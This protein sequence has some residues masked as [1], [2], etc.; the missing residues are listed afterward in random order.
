MILYIRT[1][2]NS[3]EMTDL[4][5]LNKL[6]EFLRSESLS[7]IIIP[8]NDPHFGEY[9]QDYYKVIGWLSGFTGEA[10]TLAITLD[11]AALWTDS[12][13]FIQAER[14]LKE[15]GTELK[16]LKTPGCES[17]EEWF[18]A[19]LSP[20]MKVCVDSDLY[21][22]SSFRVLKK[23]LQ[24]LDL[25]PVRDPFSSL[26][27]GRGSI[28]VEKIR[29]LGIG[30][31]GESTSSKHARIVQALSHQGEFL[32]LLSSCDDIA[33]LCNIRGNDVEYNPVALSYVAFTKE[34]L[35]LFAK[36][37]SI[38]DPEKKILEREGVIIKDYYEFEKFI[39][40]YPSDITRI[41][42]PDKLTLCKYSAATANGSD[43][44]PDNIRGGVVASLKA[45][46]NSK[47]VEGFRKAMLLDGLAWVR[48]WMWLESTIKN[49]G[50][51]PSESEVSEKLSELRAESEDYLGESFAP[52][53]AYGANAAMPHY[54]TDRNNP[55]RLEK[56]SFLLLDTGAQ[57]TFGTTDTTRTIAL[58]E[59]T[60]EQMVDYTLVLRGMISL[61]MAKFPKG[62]RGA[63]LDF[64]ARGEICRNGKIYMHGTGHGI[65][66]ALCV[67][68]GPQSIRMEENPVSLE[69]GMVLSNEPA[70]YVENEYGIRTENTILCRE[71]KTTGWGDFYEFET[72]NLVPI[73]K[74]GI[75]ISLLG[76]QATGWLNN[77]HSMVREKLS[78][79]LNNE[80]KL[81][82]AEKTA[83]LD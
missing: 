24:P 45:V 6:R 16:R 60:D 28:R 82:L 13:F 29:T 58:G 67:H 7:G 66:H 5:N 50:P 72:L 49:D 17:V 3:D 52:I 25:V 33:W 20:G 68:E 34:S 18:R 30:I 77:Y 27:K 64:L 47:E 61:S 48:M 4:N 56:R 23:N 55:A 81:W 79:Y 42:S 32:Y 83:D 26:W 51:L 38:P 1:D 70:V 8:S 80:E 35:F 11:E 21:S 41:A 15:S 54:E 22:L 9:I 75:N 10:G 53:S 78:P 74:K 59:L 31:T 19:R 2:S 46:K 39:T 71:W 57:Y 76:Q 73:D 63:Q 44:I 62:T 65:G 43:F 40:D 12:R 14:Q 37:G 36:K 69:P